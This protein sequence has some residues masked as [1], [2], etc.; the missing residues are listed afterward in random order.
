VNIE[1]TTAEN[2]AFIEKLQDDDEPYY[3]ENNSRQNLD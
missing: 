3:E 2:Q 1:E